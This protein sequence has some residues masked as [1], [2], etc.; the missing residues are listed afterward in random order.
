MTFDGH[1][2]TLERHTPDFTPLAFHQ[3]WQGTLSP[4]GHTIHG[5]WETSPDGQTWELDF[6]LTYHRL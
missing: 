5:R 6:D 1:D 2:W 4:D 3:R